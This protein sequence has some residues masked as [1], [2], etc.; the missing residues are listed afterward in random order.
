MSDCERPHATVGRPAA[1]SAFTVFSPA[2]DAT[3]ARIFGTGKPGTFTASSPTSRSWPPIR[4]QS[5][6]TCPAAWSSYTFSG[7]APG[8]I[9]PAT[10]IPFASLPTATS[11]TAAPVLS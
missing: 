10:Q 4:R 7:S 9:A 6:D 2:P 1:T 11:A 5:P 3:R 8:R